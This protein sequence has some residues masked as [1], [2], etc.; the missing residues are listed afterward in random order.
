[1]QERTRSPR[2]PSIS[3]KVAIDRVEKL[4]EKEKT[5]FVAADVAA[6]GLGYKNASSGPAGG[7]LAALSYYGLVRRNGDGKVSVSPDFEKF[8]FAPSEDVKGQFLKNWLRGPKVFLELIEKYGETPPSESAL[9]YELI[10]AG[11][12]PAAADDAAA[13][14]RESLDFVKETLGSQ[15]PSSDASFEEAPEKDP[16]GF[17]EN[18]TP[19]APHNPRVTLEPTQHKTTVLFLSQNREATLTVP[20]PF[21]TKDKKAIAKQLEALLTDDDEED[22]N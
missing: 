14:F 7:M 15:V 1:M 5:H 18:P 10:E 20:R 21:L 16:A 3:L 17:K 9:K 22:A 2:C 12:K 8:K 6:Q 11:F 4:Y 13:V 19:E